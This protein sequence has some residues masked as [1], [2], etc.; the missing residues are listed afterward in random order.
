MKRPNRYMSHS[1]LELLREEIDTMVK[2]GQMMPATHG[3]SKKG[4]PSDTNI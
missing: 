3:P 4:F 2:N 1:E